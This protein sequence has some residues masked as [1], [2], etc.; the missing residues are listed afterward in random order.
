MLESI[1]TMRRVDAQSEEQKEMILD[2]FNVLCSCL[3]SHDGNKA[4]FLE[5]EGISL[6]LL[7]ARKRKWLRLQCF[8]VLDFAL[9]GRKDG[10][11]QFIA[12]AG[13]GVLFSVLMNGA[14]N[15]PRCR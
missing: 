11:D 7:L 12:S 15:V 8:K 10:C 14:V 4:M 6:M 2:L 3:S 1:G 5:L 13:L 9:A